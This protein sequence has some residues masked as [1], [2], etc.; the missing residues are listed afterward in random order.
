MN[1]QP[2]GVPTPPPDQA[3]VAP[4]ND[5]SSSVSEAHDPAE[6]QDLRPAAAAK[7]ATL[8]PAPASAP[9]A[10][11][12]PTSFGRYV[13]KE[14]LG[15]GAFGTVYLGHDHELDRPVAIKVHRHDRELSS[16]SLQEFQ[17]EARRLAKLKHPGIVAVHD[18]GAQGDQVYIVSDFVQGITLRDRLKK[19]P[20]NWQ[21]SVRIV[22][23]MADALAHAHSQRTVHRDI[24][25]A[26]IIIGVDQKP[27]LV[28]F[29]L[30]LDESEMQGR[31]RGMI[32]GT[33]AYMSPEQAS[34]QGHR[35]DGRTDIYALGVVLF[36]MITGHVP[37]RA[38]STN[39]LLRQVREDEPQ[40]PRQLVPHIPRALEQIILKA[41]AKRVN[42][43][44]ITA[45]DMA[46]DLWKLLPGGDAGRNFDAPADSS[47]VSIP[48]VSQQVPTISQVES[49]LRCPQCSR[50]NP[51]TASFC[52]G[53]GS[54]IKLAA[55]PART[56][57][58]ASSKST[59]SLD[60]AIS[61]VQRAR[62]AERRQITL[63]TCSCDLFESAEFIEDLDYEE[64]HDIK[65]AYQESCAS[66]IKRY[67]G[68]VIQM[69]EEATL[70]CFGYPI[71]YEDAAARAVRTGLG[72]LKEIAALKGRLNRDKGITFTMTVH[73]HTG[74]AV[75][76]DAPEGPGREA[77]S[78]VG[79][80]RNVISRL[81]AVARPDVVVISQTTYRLIQG[82]FIC[83]S[84][85]TAVIKGVAKPLEFFQ[86]QRENEA[87]SRIDVAV[88]TGLTPLIGRDTEVGM[89]R[90]RWEQAT[91]GMGQ[92]VLIIGDAGL[93]KSRLVHVIKEHVAA[94]VTGDDRP[95]VEWRCTPHHQN[96]SLY[97][98]IDYFERRLGFERDEAPQLK[99][100]KL[101]QHLQSLGLA[102]DAIV[103]YVAALLSLPL[104][105]QYEAITLTPARQKE[106]TLEAIL[107]WMR[108]HATK[109]PFLFVIEDLH[110]M[111]PS[112]LELL[113]QHVESGFNDRILTILTFRPEF[114]TPW[115]SKAH[116]TAMALNRLSRKQMT[117]MMQQKTGVKKLPPAL[118]E[119]IV[120][121]TDGVPL[122]VEEYT[123]MVMESDRL[124]D[125]S[126]EVAMAGSFINQQIPA[127][128]QD[129]LMARLDRMA[130]NREVVQIAA[131]LGREFSY[132]LIKAVTP[133][134]ESEL[135][136]ELDKLVVAELLY[137][138]GKP[139]QST[140]L[141]KHAL[142]Q[143]AAYQS[144][145][146][147]KK[148]QVHRRI[149]VALEKQFGEMVQNQPELLAYHFTEA[150]LVP[151]GI[152]YWSKAGIRSQE[153]MANVEAASHLRRGLEM[154]ASLPD[155]PERA[156]QELGMQIPLGTVLI[157]SQGYAAPDVGPIFARARE[158]C[159]K[160]GQ[161]VSLMAVLWGIWAWRVVREE[162]GL[163][164]ELS[165]E[166]MQLALAQADDGIRMEAHFVPGLTLFYRGD[167]VKCR[168]HL[169]KGIALYDAER[170]RVWSRY[171]GQ[172]A[173]VTC[174]S[175]L[176]LSLWCQGYPDQALK[177]AQDAVKLA[178]ELK[179]PFSR[180]YA[181]HH[182][183]WLQQHL[184]MGK[185]VQTSAD[186][187]LVIATEQGFPFWK[188]VGVLCRSA[189]LL[190]QNKPAEALE[191]ANQGLAAFRATGA[192]LS[193]AQY[194]G[195]FA[196]AHWQLGKL[197][198]A[199]KYVEEA[200]AAVAAN[201]NDFFLSELYRLKGEIM[202]A[203]SPDNRV[204]A[205]ACFQD[206]LAVAER[207][208]AKSWELRATMSLGR[209]W[210]QQGR[211]A[212][213]RA[214]L[215][216]IYEWFTEGLTTPDL[217]DAKK[218]L[219][220]WA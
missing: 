203:Q 37:F 69:T 194:L 79:E 86:V 44:F 125:D 217:E 106:K 155:T 208:R 132:E 100:E 4:A 141:F 159:L 184:R 88:P 211:Q 61:S 176:A 210:Q 55:S 134:A 164:M 48:G 186:A 196:E 133:L 105:N 59:S 202:L 42:D 204:E 182:L 98:I 97:P 31:Q 73:V 46:E 21:E 198:D 24:K 92:I 56:D 162:F 178:G 138:K 91:E 150:G 108:V 180:C 170:C 124:R 114:E 51:V 142:I 156:G 30:G 197:D 149:A 84:L 175:Y 71:A 163:C 166:V 177:T 95:I 131:T 33:P 148:Q 143:D 90:D 110:W 101:D 77:F 107:E 45:N 215:A 22:A 153:R 113:A 8:V 116:Q 115:K 130:S 121:K 34:G 200:F 127:T 67:D 35:I 38:P 129:L 81:D 28:D 39:E 20:F 117:E 13:V 96:S 137:Q 195:Y 118:V 54:A 207:Q 179:H 104:G 14:T 216:P 76:S 218:L 140:Y 89:L 145:L 87:R 10:A 66:V 120:A 136:A 112:T 139:P 168:E 188:A 12:L 82:F 201:H 165:K 36:E 161:P 68:T 119:Q 47:S 102:N 183:G 193:L 1:E 41:M 52:I 75:V 19:Q 157:A 25:P 219:E 160:I 172:N 185:A 123:K 32:A 144:L 70:A 17:Q 209:L 11:K 49:S 50:D 190:L 99:F 16:D 147:S 214:R 213:A 94:Q 9:P 74:M 63:L 111:D 205:E 43:R 80:A 58:P 72:I 122:F 26:N 60:K 3:L 23:A 212:D 199:L 7:P 18:F 171:T 151:Q 169:E 192:A 152:E 78:V 27:V 62:E 126:G 29:G 158:L 206:A 15:S 167:F 64:Q 135:Q 146:K 220:A 103:P 128:L 187:E 191:Q 2:K 6:T 53:C 93:G 40:P 174:R 65:S 5:V 109:Q 83:E 189:G 154:L 173:G 181:I 57:E 85:G